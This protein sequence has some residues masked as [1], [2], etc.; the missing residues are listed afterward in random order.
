LLFCFQ[1]LRNWSWNIWNSCGADNRK[2]RTIVASTQRDDLTTARRLSY[3]GD[4]YT[5]KLQDTRWLCYQ[6][7]PFCV[8]R[9]TPVQKKSCMDYYRSRIGA[10]ESWRV[11]V[12]PMTLKW[13]RKG[14]FKS[15]ASIL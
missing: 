12:T 2:H 1:V 10:A 4:T 14:F 3:G 6:Q 5:L 13:V 11:L 9:C 8:R 15:T 7:L